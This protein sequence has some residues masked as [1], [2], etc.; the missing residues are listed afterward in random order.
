[1]GHEPYRKIQKIL[2]LALPKACHRLP[3]GKSKVAEGKKHQ[4]QPTH[5]HQRR[6]SP[7]VIDQ[8]TKVI[9]KAVQREAFGDARS[10]Y[11][12]DSTCN[13]VKIRKNILKKS[14]LYQLDPYVDDVDILRVG[15]RLR[16]TNFSFNKK[17]P[18]LLPKGHHVS[19]LLVCYYHEKV[20]HRGCQITH[21]GE[22]CE[23]LLMCHLQKA[24]RL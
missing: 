21:Q 16:N 19:M 18:V 9:I 1:M 12:S 13:I 24:T 7:E 8:A 15:G 10:T 20:Y 17:H 6:L 2:F 22:P 4:P 14:S 3:K 11:E 5:T 23:T